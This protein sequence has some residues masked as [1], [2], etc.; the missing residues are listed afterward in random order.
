MSPA[1][2]ITL[3]VVETVRSTCSEAV[4]GAG[5]MGVGEDAGADRHG[6]LAAVGVRGLGRTV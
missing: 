5:K 6:N 2:M 4:V 3:A 1:W